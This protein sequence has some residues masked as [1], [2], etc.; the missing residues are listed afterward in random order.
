MNQEKPSLR[1][2]RWMGDCLKVL[3]SFPEEVQ[4]DIGYSL[5][6]VQAGLKPLEAKPLKGIDSGV[7][8]IVTRYDGDSYRTIYATKLGEYLYVL[9]VF[10]K[11]S[12][13]GI[14]TTQQDIDLVIKRL[15]EAKKLEEK[16]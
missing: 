10:Q 8:E 3:R 13:S 12:K 4:H 11:K 14:K 15:K 5:M 9:H 2:V 7:L 1:P 16:S 6:L